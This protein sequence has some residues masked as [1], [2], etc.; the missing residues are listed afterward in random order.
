MGQG[1]PGGPDAS[2][3]AW[4]C[5]LTQAYN[6]VIDGTGGTILHPITYVS[7]L[8]QSSQLNWTILTKEAYGIYMSVKKL[9]FYLDDADITL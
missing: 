7:A 9:S 4:A 6:H 2:K 1:G 5:V 3:Y 8:F